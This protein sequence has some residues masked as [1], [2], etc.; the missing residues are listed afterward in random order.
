MEKLEAK[1]QSLKSQSV[2]LLV[3]KVIGFALSF[4]L[5]LII[6]RALSQEDVGHYREAFQVITNAV[7]ILPLG[8]SMSAFYFLSR[9]RDR[10]R[11][12][13]LNILL[14]NFTVGGLA[15]LTMVLFPSL[16]GDFFNAPELTQ[17]GPTIGLVIWV[18]IFSAFLETVAIANSETRIATVF[19][20]FASLSKTLLMGGGVF[21]FGTVSSLIYAA[22]LQGVIQ[23]AILLVY[24]HKRFP[25]YWRMFD[26]RFL[27]EHARYAIPF[28]LTA[29]VWLAQSDIHNYFVGYKFSS[30]EF[31]V[32]AYGCFQIPL[33]AMLADSVTSVLIPHM[34]T[35]QQ[36]GDR[37]EM[38]RL[39]ARAMQKLALVYFPLYVFLMITAS[40][41]ITTLFTHQYDASVPIFMVNLTLL[42]LGILITDPIV[43]SY[44]ELGRL[45]LLNRLLIFS[46]LVA[47]LY[48]GLDYLGLVGIISVAIGALVVEKFICETMVIRKLGVGLKHLYLLKQPAKT[49]AAS[50]IAGAVTYLVYTNIHVYLE[51][52]GEDFARGFFHTEEMSTLNFFG[53]SLVLLICGMV[54]GPIYVIAA[55]SLGLIEESEKELVRKYL[56]K[57]LP[58]RSTLRAVDTQN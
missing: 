36:T 3:A 17:L 54:F 7:I 9:E 52:V 35:L 50:L 20:V 19:I 26:A 48:F 15:A 28:G 30:A 1:T 23:T 22:L 34:N 21:Y 33:I 10:R 49:A 39:T 47:V 18:T 42:P 12:A 29:I 40:T 38:I 25:G 43:R 37:D 45:F 16:L 32:Y 51:L 27:V 56:R 14:F 31:A 13:V 24:L 2:W 41:F 53:G 44:K 5:P 57:F 8:F 11:A 55:H 58:G 6:V 46:I 4:M